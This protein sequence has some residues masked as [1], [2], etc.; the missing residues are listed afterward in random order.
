MFLEHGSLFTNVSMQSSHI[1]TAGLSMISK[2][3]KSKCPL[4]ETRADMFEKKSKIHNECKDIDRYPPTEAAAAEHVKRLYLQV[5]TWNGIR[6]EPLNWGFFLRDGMMLPI[7]T[8]QDIA[9]AK[10]LEKIKCSCLTSCTKRCSCKIFGIEC[11]NNCKNCTY[12]C[13]NR[14]PIDDDNDHNLFVE[15]L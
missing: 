7:M 14:A 8:T 9:P 4:D 3:Y 12:S 1:V 13:L 6:I 5:C 15:D 2:L 11:S 10:V